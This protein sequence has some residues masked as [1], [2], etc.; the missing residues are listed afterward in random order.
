MRLWRCKRRSDQPQPEGLSDEQPLEPGD[1]ND[2]AWLRGGQL[3]RATLPA[4]HGLT[5]ALA[6]ARGLRRF[7]IT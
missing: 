2:A 4:G 6:T 3:Q 5:D 7:R 1:G